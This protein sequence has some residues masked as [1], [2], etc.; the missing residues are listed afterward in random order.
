MCKKCEHFESS[1]L[2]NINFIASVH[3]CFD[4]LSYLDIKH[5]KY[6][7]E[8]EHSILHSNKFIAPIHDLYDPLSKYELSLKLKD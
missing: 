2:H 5:T 7:R 3:E 6:K 1:I 8:F 4:T